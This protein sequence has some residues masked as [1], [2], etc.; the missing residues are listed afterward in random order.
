[1]N[2][3]AKPSR[4]PRRPLCAHGRQSVPNK[5]FIDMDRRDFFSAAGALGLAS[6]AAEVK[7]RA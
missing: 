3:F 2:V 1:V 7:V 5:R 6:V 4:A